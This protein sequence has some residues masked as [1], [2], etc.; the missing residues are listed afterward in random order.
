MTD[1]AIAEVEIFYDDAAVPPGFFYIVT[2][3]EGADEKV[4]PFDTQELAEEAFEHA[5]SIVILN[6]V[7]AGLG[8]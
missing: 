7:K 4:G 5:M 3:D 1:I 6:I 2:T 8:L